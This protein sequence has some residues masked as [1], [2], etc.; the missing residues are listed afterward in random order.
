MYTKRKC[1]QLKH[2][3][4]Y[5]K[6]AKHCRKKNAG[7]SFIFYISLKDYI[8]KRTLLSLEIVIFSDFYVV[9]TI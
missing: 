3:V 9:F 4:L 7:K 2:L 5:F 6:L 8:Q 1:S